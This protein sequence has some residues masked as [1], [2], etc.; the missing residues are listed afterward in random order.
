MSRRRH[1]RAISRALAARGGRLPLAAGRIESGEGLAAGERFGTGVAVGL[2]LAALAFVAIAVLGV[3]HRD[4][5]LAAPVNLP[6]L[7]ATMPLHA[8]FVLAPLLVGVLH[9]YALAQYARARARGRR[10]SAATPAAGSP[11]DGAIAALSQGIVFLALVVVPVLVLV[12]VQIQ[13]LPAHDPAITWLHR[14]VILADVVLIWLVWPAAVDREERLAGPDLRRPGLLIAGLVPI[15]FAFTAATFPGEWLDHW[16]GR[17]QWIPRGAAV[18]AEAQ[19]ETRW[20]SFHDLLFHGDIDEVGRRRKSL[21]SNTLVLSG[22]DAPAAAGL[23]DPQAFEAARRSLAFRG[24]RLEGAVLIGADL[25]KADLTGARLEG[26]RLE[27]A[28]LQGA[29]LDDAWLEGADLGE[30]TLRGALLQLA[31]LKAARL[32]GAQLQG[33]SLVSAQLQGASLKEAQLQDAALTNAQLQGASLVSARLGGATLSYA[34]LQGAK[35]DGAEL[36]GAVLDHAQMQ[37]ASLGSSQLQGASL[38]AVQLQG[39]SLDRAEL[40]GAMLLGVNL[41]G[42]S[43]DHAGLQG[44]MLRDAGFRGASLDNA[45][46]QGAVL[47]Y[48]QFQGALLRGS[49]LQGASLRGATLIGTSLE[50]A[51]IWRARFEEATIRG[52]YEDGIVATPP[53]AR[54]VPAANP[55]GRA[56][57]AESGGAKAAYVALKALIVHEIPRAQKR[58]DVMKRIAVLD[59]ETPVPD[60]AAGAVLDPGRVDKA[61]YQKVMAEGLE[62]LACGGG[63]FDREILRGLVRS[64]R[65]VEAGPLARGL[66]EA[67]LAPGCPVSAA[68]SEADK[69]A[70]AKAADSADQALSDPAAEPAAASATGR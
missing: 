62:T 26:A 67:V 54:I 66:V 1:E 40:Q 56:E 63:D 60:S 17:Q 8:F 3:T 28:D 25:R 55:S 41:D 58:E 59:P 19:G 24:R 16:V 20:T 38:L 12:L 50:R 43:L 44:A 10:S 65:I 48:A 33:A 34:Q 13:F 31:R 2:Y 4:L 21:F 32:E 35:L 61:T 23:A 36:Q 46:L 6:L 39:A 37:G 11:R 29:L 45:Q 68:L 7:G 64:K 51:N 9:A 15:G 47:D 57:A 49:Q 14:F 18:G 69:E 53:V 42:A 27:R 52:V 30:A 22:F 70:L 5:F